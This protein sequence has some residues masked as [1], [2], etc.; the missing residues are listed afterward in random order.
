MNSVLRIVFFLSCVSI[1][2]QGRIT[3]PQAINIIS[4][5]SMLSQRMAKDKIY[6]AKTS[7]GTRGLLSSVIQFENNLNSLKSVKVNEGTQSEITHLELLWL[8]YKMNIEE[9]SNNS[10]R[11]IMQYNRIVL[12]LCTNISTSLLKVAQEKK[13]YPFN[14]DNEDFHNA[15]KATNNLKYAAQRLALYYTAY[16]YKITKY[17]NTE[18]EEIISTIEGEIGKI[19][20]IKSTNTEYI[21]DTN[22]IE[23]EWTKMISGLT[24]IR[25][26][27]FISVNTSTKPEA[28][29]DASNRLL[30]LSDLL[31]RTYKAVNEINN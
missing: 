4:K 15:F 31:G 8:G 20:K 6:N 9:E 10:N 22:L 23:S 28:I 12:D 7:N 17:D 30:K 18:F 26:K 19:S 1:F 14:T 11:D 13:Q 2:S 5:Q 27:K 24:E 16:Y 3:I 25:A 29:Y 21:G